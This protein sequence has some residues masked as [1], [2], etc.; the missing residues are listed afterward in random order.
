M[1]RADQPERVISRYFF[2]EANFTDLLELI[3]DACQSR[4]GISLTSDIN[5]LLIDTMKSVFQTK[6]LI[7][8]DADRNQI[9]L[10]LN[11]MVL[12]KCFDIIHQELQ[13]QAVSKDQEVYQEE[14]ASSRENFDSTSDRS[15]DTPSGKA[16]FDDQLNDMVK[17]R[18]DEKNRFEGKGGHRTPNDQEPISTDGQSKP[19]G[20]RENF[21][22]PKPKHKDQLESTT[23][24][25]DSDMLLK[26][27]AMKR[28]RDAVEQEAA[29]LLKAEAG[30][31]S[32]H[33]RMSKSG[34]S[35]SNLSSIPEEEEIDIKED[36]ATNTGSNIEQDRELTDGLPDDIWSMSTD[37]ELS[38]E[39]VDV[40]SILPTIPAATSAPNVFDSKTTMKSMEKGD[41][42]DDK[43][44]K[45]NESFQALL[46]QRMKEAQNL[47]FPAP[48]TATFDAVQTNTPI[49]DDGIA[50][51]K[52]KWG[53]KRDQSEDL[54]QVCSR[55]D[56]VISG[57]ESQ[58]IWTK[59]MTDAFKRLSQDITQNLTTIS[60]DLSK[61]IE[62]ITE[63]K[64]NTN[65]KTDNDDAKPS[66][67]ITKTSRVFTSLVRD[68]SSEPGDAYDFTIEATA[69]KIGFVRI[70][71]PI[72]DAI[73]P[74][75]SFPVAFLNIGDRSSAIQLSV[76][77]REYMT[78]DLS[79]FNETARQPQSQSQVQYPKNDKSLL[80][81][82]RTRLV[83]TG[84]FGYPLL[85]PRDRSTINS[86]QPNNLRTLLETKQDHNLRTGER[87]IL[88]GILCE[89]QEISE[90]YNRDCG[91]EAFVIDSSHVE[92]DSSTA[93]IS[94]VSFL[95]AKIKNGG[96]LIKAKAQTILLV[97][98][99]SVSV[100]SVRSS[101]DG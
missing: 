43:R 12:T 73:R 11:K 42:R 28:S 30:F 56:H 41:A 97:E 71:F 24:D 87:I 19:A 46:D 32:T 47:K 59:T 18:N 8:S 2:S 80:H 90:W 6:P 50:I 65:T 67:E 49:P 93:V 99:E 21:V 91:H 101:N 83:L 60:L 53:L 94:Y 5:V 35:T 40:A 34:Q 85:A 89:E 88:D 66:S 22:I 16:G 51:A 100:H 68:R 92:I 84:A 37:G 74:G 48:T 17:L 70:F 4:F 61:A 14:D 52:M 3:H 15:F 63:T 10:V 86:I 77:D 58:E 38:N 81:Q 36:E 96:Q 98:E 78:C 29:T 72:G 45:A 75:C 31:K 27:E 76:H 44:P 57:M 25:K 33:A 69:K 79:Q 13:D 62:K 20:F 7:G 64:T 95:T 82:R 39:Y 1:N 23:I 55:F 54:S 9:V 26:Y